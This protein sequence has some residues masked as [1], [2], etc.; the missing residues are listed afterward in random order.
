M[1]AAILVVYV[2]M[3]I[4]LVAA[5]VIRIQLQLARGIPLDA[6]P[7]IGGSLGVLALLLLIPAFEEWRERRSPGNR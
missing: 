6:L 1:R 2:V 7:F 4:Y 3:G 5:S